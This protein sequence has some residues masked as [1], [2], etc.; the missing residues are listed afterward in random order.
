M[1]V[2]STVVIELKKEGHA[3]AGLAEG[4]TKGGCRS[5]GQGVLKVGEHFA[6]VFLDNV[7]AVSS[8]QDLF[9]QKESWHAARGESHHTEKGTVVLVI[10][11]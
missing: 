4:I 3:A 7:T 10:P 2:A 8:V 9:G 1:V 5:V 6:K 11:V